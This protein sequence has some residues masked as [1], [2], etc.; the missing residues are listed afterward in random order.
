MIDYQKFDNTELA[1]E[2]VLPLNKKFDILFVLDGR[3]VDIG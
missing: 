2:N 1:K 3:I